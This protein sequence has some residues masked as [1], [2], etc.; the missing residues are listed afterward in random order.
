MTVRKGEGGGERVF[1]RS[2]DRWERGEREREEGG[3]GGRWA[4]W[5]ACVG[6]I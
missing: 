5:P 6:L 1:K 3:W 4:P 2:C